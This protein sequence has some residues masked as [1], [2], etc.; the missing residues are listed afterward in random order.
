M[1]GQKSV[2]DYLQLRILSCYSEALLLKQ[3]K[4][5]KPRMAIVYPTYVCNHSCLGCDYIRLNKTKHSLSERQFMKVI[6]QLID[7]G[8]QGI[9]FCGGGE[10]TLHAS[11]P[12][13]L[14]K[15]IKH[16]ITFGFL[17]NGTNLNQKL[18]EQLVKKGSYCRVSLESATEKIFNFYKRP[19]NKKAGFENVL[20]NI[21]NLVSLRNSCLPQT[22][23][24][25]SIKY[26]VDN[27]NFSDVTK[28]VKFAEE[29]KVDS[30]QFKLAR[31]VDSELKDSRLVKKLKKEVAQ[32]KHDY[33]DLRIMANFEKSQLKDKCWLAPLQLVVD[34]Y[35]DVYICCY[36]HHR[37]KNHCLG[38]MLKQDLKTIWH[39]KKTQKK[40][41]EIDINDCNK[42]DCR[43]HYYNELM[44]KVVI[45]DIGQ[46][47]F[48]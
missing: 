11:L 47:N 25:I 41:A 28:A 21:K 1:R 38:N 22:K 24:Q 15:L 2:L 20:K 26:T 36:Y 19:I 48:I 5:P 14:D 12:K 46:L 39:S 18:Q 27:N 45:D 31:N 16:N 42:Y 23:L 32:M 8:V 7:I 34:P 6:N 17:T 37:I 9:E 35:G 4:M 10:P 13:V 40:L 3:G 30:I 43:F 44:R 33:P 29:L